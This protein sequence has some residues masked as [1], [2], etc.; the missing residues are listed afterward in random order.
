MQ[1][2]LIY[3]IGKLAEY[4]DFVF[5][6][7]STYE[8]IGF[9]IERGIVDEQQFVFGKPLTILDKLEKLF[10]PSEYKIFIAVGNNSIRNRIFEHIKSLGFSFANYLSTKSQYWFDCTLGEN[11][12]L[13]EG[14]TIQPFVSIGDNTLIFSSII[15][16]HSKIDSH[17]TLS[18]CCIG[19]G[20]T[21]KSHTFIGMNATVNQNVIIE[22]NNIIGVGCNIIKNTKEN[23][24]YSTEKTRLRLFSST[25]IFS[26]FLK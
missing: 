3:G 19:G 12:L 26:T 9:C 1:K 23:E 6:N 17:S 13:S 7:D 15:G 21:V 10:C 4:A 18:G 25:K 5:T 2:L 16:H 8:V 24:V 22:K 14:C 20:V 11:I